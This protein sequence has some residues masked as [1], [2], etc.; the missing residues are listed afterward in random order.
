MMLLKEYWGQGIGKKLLEVLIAHAQ[1]HGIVR[2]GARVRVHNER[3]IALYRK[4]GFTIEGTRAKAALI[5]GVFFDEFY[6]VKM[7]AEFT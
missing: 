6:I 5:D 7:L 4:M 3:A 1:H 2:L